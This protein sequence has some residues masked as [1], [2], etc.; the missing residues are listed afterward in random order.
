MCD[1]IN[2]VFSFVEYFKI[3]LDF[4]RLYNEVNLCFYDAV[5][6][7]N[8]FLHERANLS[9]HKAAAFVSFE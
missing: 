2:A 7:L 3:N 1:Q 5:L 4:V 9:C 6:S 8:G